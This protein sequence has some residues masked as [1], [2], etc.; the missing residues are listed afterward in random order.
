M[1]TLGAV[2]EVAFSKLNPHIFFSC[3]QDRTGFEVEGRG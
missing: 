3:S 1:Y 2:N